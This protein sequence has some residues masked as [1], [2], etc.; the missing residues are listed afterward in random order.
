M[1][2]VFQTHPFSRVS[3]VAEY[4]AEIIREQADLLY[5]DAERAGIVAIIGTGILGLLVGVT[6]FYF[7]GE[8]NEALAIVLTLGA[9]IA[10]A[11]AGAA[12]GAGRSFKLRSQAQQLLVLVAI[13]QNTRSASASQVRPSSTASAPTL[14]VKV[15]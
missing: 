5:E 1:E 11:L 8:R 7:L 3:E 6:C 10:G 14:D 9:P 2:A 13:E 4:D 15:G 12:M